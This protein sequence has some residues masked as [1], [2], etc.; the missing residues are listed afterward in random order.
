[1]S[2]LRNHDLSAAFTQGPERRRPA[3]RGKGQTSQ[4]KPL[5]RSMRSTTTAQVSSSARDNKNENL[6]ARRRSSRTM[7]LSQIPGCPSVACDMSAKVMAT[8][9]R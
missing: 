9:A 8:H 7:P 5:D 3:P 1:M 2:L 4:S 6:H